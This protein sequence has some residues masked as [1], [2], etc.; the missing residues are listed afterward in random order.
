MTTYEPAATPLGPAA[1]PH[2]QLAQNIVLSFLGG[3]RVFELKTVQIND[4]LTIPRPCIDMQTVGYNVEWS[5]ELTLEQSLEEYVKAAMLLQILRRSDLLQLA[6]GADA[7]LFDLSV[8]Y[9]LA[10]IQSDRVRAFLAGLRDA[11]PVI[12]RLRRQIPDEYRRFRD[13]DFPTQISHT[14]TLSTFHGCPPDEIERMID[15]LLR[16]EGLDCVIKL[17]PTLLGPQ[18]ARALFNERLGY[19]EHIP[20][21]A[22]A[23]DTTWAQA[24]DFCGRLGETAKTLGRGFGV[25]FSNTLIVEN[26][27]SFFPATEKVMYLSGP[28]LHVL[29]MSLVLRFR[30]AFGDRFPISFSAGIDRH[31]FADAVSLGLV[32]V[33]VCS[34]LLRTGGY[35]RMQSYFAELLG[36]MA[37]VAA[38]NIDSARRTVTTNELIFQARDGRESRC[39]SH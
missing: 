38:T 17:N 22:F 39:A 16:E 19:R 26:H 8:G 14:L 21:E 13:L 20:D 18:E 30:E 1:G 35:G 27:R 9:D 34:D 11:T 3:A 32:P 2:S 24:V 31:N 4:R 5:Q 15:W 29:A 6:P 10:G 37:R 28:P 25:K 36:R 12:D 7:A 33:T 23:K